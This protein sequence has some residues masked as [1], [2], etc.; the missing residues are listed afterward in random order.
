[1]RER[2]RSTLVKVLYELT[3]LTCITPSCLY[4]PPLSFFFLFFFVV[5]FFFFFFF[6]H[7]LTVVKLRLP[8]LSRSLVSRTP[9]NSRHELQY[10][11]F[12]GIQHPRCTPFSISAHVIFETIRDI[13]SFG[14][15]RMTSISTSYNAL[16]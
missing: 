14:L 2:L 15:R 12:L 8:C 10:K 11:S 6:Q 9:C 4:L 13:H 1:M 3:T 16:L 5:V 7:L